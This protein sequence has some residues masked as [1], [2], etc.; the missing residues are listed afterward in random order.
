MHS[1][2]V[3]ISKSKGIFL[4]WM[5]AVCQALT[6]YSVL[7]WVWWMSLSSLHWWG[8][9]SA[10]PQRD[11]TYN[12]HE[13]SPGVTG[14]PRFKSIPDSKFYHLPAPTVC[15]QKGVSIEM[16]PL[17]RDYSGIQGLWA[18]DIQATRL[19]LCFGCKYILLLGDNIGKVHSN[20]TWIRKALLPRY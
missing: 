2:G 12:G 16:R 20:V 3:T 9:S 14:R 6:S 1:K 19:S 15:F 18:P 8:N 11:C 7:T 4:Y 17:P 10:I 13:V 5:P